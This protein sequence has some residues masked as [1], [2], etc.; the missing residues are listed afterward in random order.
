MPAKSGDA[1]VWEG[2]A[3]GDATGGFSTFFTPSTTGGGCWKNWP[4]RD[5]TWME[6]KGRDRIDGWRGGRDVEGKDIV[7]Y[8]EKGIEQN[9]HRM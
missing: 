7:S 2:G 6:R 3:L 8:Y 5:R 4:G 1:Q 9:C